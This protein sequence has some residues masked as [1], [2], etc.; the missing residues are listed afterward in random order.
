MG[1]VIAVL[2]GVLF[3]VVVVAIAVRNGVIG[4]KN[5]V[6]NAF[7]GIDAQLK[8]RYDL[9]PN[10]IAAV[11][12]AMDHERGTLRE[13]TELRVRAMSGGLSPTERVAVDQQLASAF[14]TAMV[15]VEA[16][17]QIRATGNVE[18]LQR[19]L[20]EVEEQLSA[21]RRSYNAAVTDYNNAL[22]MFPS[23]IFARSLG[24]TRKEVLSLPEVERKNVDVGA[25]MAR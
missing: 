10:L 21:A 17:P 13:L 7:G 11:K 23:S 6:D 22:E 2:G 18:L 16:Y 8:K 1:T 12:G 3:L 20:N 14:R 19:S 15:E 25:L 5:A 4:R 24:Y 9:V